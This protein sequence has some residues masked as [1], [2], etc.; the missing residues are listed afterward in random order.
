M[1]GGGK[2]AA[3]SVISSTCD[4]HTVTGLNVQSNAEKHVSGHFLIMGLKG[5]V[6]KRVSKQYLKQWYSMELFRTK[7][8]KCGWAY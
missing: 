8:E 6:G 7:G 2:K 1:F 5:I 3:I 4:S